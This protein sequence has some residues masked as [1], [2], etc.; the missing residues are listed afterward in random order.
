MAT[1]V[2]GTAGH[3]DHGKTTLLR[4]ITGIDADR[5]PEERARGLTIDVGYAHLDLDDGTS[6]DFVDVPGHDRYVGNMLVGAGEIDAALLVVA[7][8]DGPR[9]Q[10]LEH[11]ELLDGLGIR[12]GVAVVTKA[13]AVAAARIDEVAADVQALLD[14]TTLEGSPILVASGVSGAG[15]PGVVAALHA[16]RDRV[17]VRRQAAPAGP[18]RLAIDRVFTVKGR[19][20]VVTGSLRGGTIAAGDILRLEP[21]GQPVRVRGLEVHNRSA[22]A[23]DGGRT[24]LNV[25]GIAAGQL[26]RGHV[27]TGDPG[28]EPSDRPFVR[29]RAIV[30]LAGR[31]GERWPP[32]HGTVL[33]LHLG[34]GQVDAEVR[35]RG[36]EAIDL[37][38]GSIG[39]R[40]RLTEPV[41][42]FVGDRG[43]LRRPSPG[44]PIASL[45]VLDPIAPRGVA[46]R[47]INVERAR[48]LAEAVES[49]DAA[50]AADALVAL[51]GALPAARVMAVRNALASAGE[52]EAAASGPATGLVLAP[53]VIAALE[54]D[55]LGTVS[56]SAG[57]SVADVRSIALRSL[58]RRSALDRDAGPA[59]IQAVDAVI[60]D[61]V[62]RGR[63]ARGGDQLRDPSAGPAIPPETSAAM[64][65][66]ERLLAVPAPLPLSEAARS[67]G[68]S[69]E[70]VRALFAA[71]RLIRLEADLAWATSTYRDLA[72]QA[73]DLATIG[74]LTPAAFRDATGT[75]RRYVLAILEDLDRREIL[76]RTPEGHV[77]G[78]RAPKPPVPA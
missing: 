27:L 33:R 19:G 29:L 2:I 53:D 74:A 37:D 75:S 41:A 61:L 12:D 4:A 57:R 73:L 48:A 68:C 5:L 6:L 36:R 15:V 45:R 50:A 60:G 11:L 51:H 70:G 3:I 55:I 39:V 38:D 77:P 43:V 42:T 24:A 47:R 17:A 21:G 49:A 13:D 8:D 65:R 40:I 30:D 71:G 34:T 69:P 22:D 67:A 72:R 28:I 63:V 54:A 25:A 20:V 9:P 44:L 76:K 58:R 46:R 26:R 64:D 14:R 62:G 16:L 1:V 78:P 23:H 10:T 66:L 35:T 31:S 59:A 7:A 56:G 18:R 32:A 52:R